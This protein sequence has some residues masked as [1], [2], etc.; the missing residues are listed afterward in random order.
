[1]S[2]F[3]EHHQDRQNCLS[4]QL[5]DLGFLRMF[6]EISGTDAYLFRS[7]FKYPCYILE[8]NY[9]FLMPKRLCSP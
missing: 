7:V 2:R 5:V 3:Q 1:M 9:K 8:R 6:V 4:I